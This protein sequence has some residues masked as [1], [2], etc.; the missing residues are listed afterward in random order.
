[1]NEPKPTIPSEEKAHP[2]IPEGMYCYTM[3]GVMPDGRGIRTK[4]CPHWGIDPNHG[5]QDNGYCKLTGLKDWVDNTLLWDQVK[6]CGIN[7]DWEDEEVLP[8]ES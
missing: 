2:E 3:L 8:D 1:M 7:Y 6:E 4:V 5:S